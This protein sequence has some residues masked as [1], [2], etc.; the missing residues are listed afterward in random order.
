[1][2]NLHGV[3]SNA[4]QPSNVGEVY[5]LT[6]EERRMVTSFRYRGSYLS[7]LAKDFAKDFVKVYKKVNGIK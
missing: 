6:R 7:G 5:I 2:I 3:S 1:V 4:F